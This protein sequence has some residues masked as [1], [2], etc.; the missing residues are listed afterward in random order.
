[1]S[2]TIETLRR[3]VDAALNAADYTLAEVKVKKALRAHSTEA[4]YLAL[5]GKVYLYAGAQK[6]ALEY[7]RQARYFDSSSVNAAAGLLLSAP[8]VA[9]VKNNDV[10]F[11][12]I[13]R[14]DTE[15]ARLAQRLYY[16]NKN[17]L[18]AAL[19]SIKAAYRANPDSMA[20]VLAYIQ[21]L[22]ANQ[23][24]DPEIETLFARLKRVHPANEAVIRA[25]IEYLYRAAQYDKC[26]RLCKR[27][28]T[29]LP[30]SETADYAR[31]ID[32]R[33]RRQEERKQQ[34]HDLDGLDGSA[35]RS[36]P[37]PTETC[38]P[39]EPSSATVDEAMARLNRL[40]G[41]TTVKEEVI[42]IHK[43]LEFDKIRRER[44]HL[45]ETEPDSYHFVFY[46]NPGTGKTTVARLLGDI[47]HSFGLLEKG[48]L[49]EVDRSGLV[50][51]Y[52]G[53]TAQK[54]RKVIEQAMGGVL[55][56]DEAYALCN[57]E[58]DDFGKEAIDTLVKAVEDH[59][60]EFIVILAGY[61]QEMYNLI[62]SNAGLES[63]FT[64]HIDFP[65]YTEEELLEIAKLIAKENHYSFSPDGEIAFKECISKRKVNKKFGNAREVRTLM[66]N[67]FAEKAMH[68]DPAI[69]S[70]EYLTLLT[71]QD[72][73]ID[74]KFSPEKSAQAALNRLQS[75]T[76]LSAV[77]EEVKSMMSLVS[78]YK[79]E[80]KITGASQTALPINMHMCFTG[81]PGTGKTTVARI[82]SEIL[83][84]IGAL[85]T[86]ELIEV[87]RGD[88]VGRYQGETAQKVA[89]CCERAY[90][91]VLFIDEAYALVQS[92]HD[93]YGLEAVAALIKEMEDHRDK[94]VVI[95][96][97]YSAEMDVFMQ[98]NSG[99]SSRI[100][101]TI[102]F[103]DYTE[104]ELYQIFEGLLRSNGITLSAEAVPRAR[105]AVHALSENRGRSFGNGRDI[106]S[107]YET[108]FKH[109]AERVQAQALTGEARKRF[110][111]EDF[112]AAV[113][114]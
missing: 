64:K 30:N 108:V 3:E 69:S 25:E 82:Y 38:F 45:E 101:K 13:Q 94:L 88:L 89:E 36:G 73:G 1:M 5:M 61:K 12:Q 4:E 2:D 50:G 32:G 15:E 54:T 71:P 65:D 91:G 90:G 28:I 63:R 85:K 70:L 92:D 110:L 93:S 67:A 75:L 8:S 33:I 105:E 80:Q 79:E 106:R 27:T 60:H 34:K 14:A 47:F 103:P 107:L 11:Q 26:R 102:E 104:T 72:F 7:Y 18:A 46:G 109:M 55:F 84:A 113:R 58:N 51:E 41:L 77:K 53:H 42:R 10:L 97:G 96:A 112:D 66:S 24:D 99:I 62:K 44:L 57:G 16:M 83:A 78:Y 23:L 22:S 100:G 56:I 35:A 21:T 81:N 114:R 86:G 87:S 29:R 98:S 95:L 74:I 111:P 37:Q 52:Q 68:F 48:H 9:D 17:D 49:I 6:K 19:Q 76:G 39:V 20:V 40:I 43:K 31:K 59:R